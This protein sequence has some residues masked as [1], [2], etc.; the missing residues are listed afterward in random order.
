M[1]LLVELALPRA[2]LQPLH[3]R[4]PR[5]GQAKLPVRR[6]LHPTSSGVR[7][8]ALL[9][10]LHGRPEAVDPALPLL[11]HEMLY[12]SQAPLQLLLPPPAPPP[13]R[14][15]LAGDVSAE[16]KTG[17]RVPVLQVVA[18]ATGQRISSLPVRLDPRPCP[19]H[20]RL[21]VLQ[22]LRKGGVGS[23]EQ[24]LSGQVLQVCT[25]EH[26]RSFLRLLLHPCL[27][28]IEGLPV[29]HGRALGE[30]GRPGLPADCSSA[31]HCVVASLPGVVCNAVPVQISRRRLSHHIPVGC[32]CR[33]PVDVGAVGPVMAG[34]RD[35]AVGH[36]RHLE[37]SRVVEGRSFRLLEQL[38]DGSELPEVQQE[39]GAIDPLLHLVGACERLVQLLLNSSL[40]ACLGHLRNLLLLGSKLLSF[41]ALDSHEANGGRRRS[42]FGSSG[43]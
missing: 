22:L 13:R 35:I 36:S 23:D 37:V 21:P 41:Q 24:T 39:A 12:S 9:L 7:L 40:L 11:V 10:L 29:D 3:I 26:V 42:E 4:A 32:R 8:P 19:S 5:G 28:L 6:F 20:G 16:G 25:H 43:T 27:L 30:R 14:H 15:G 2:P 33:K 1:N 34:A 38:G 18:R 31:W 17:R